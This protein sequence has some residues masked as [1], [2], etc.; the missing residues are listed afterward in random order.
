MERRGHGQSGQIKPGVPWAKRA[1]A[2]AKS[3]PNQRAAGAGAKF[4]E[5]VK[6]LFA[7]GDF[8]PKKGFGAKKGA[9]FLKNRQIN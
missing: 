5:S 2:A 8:L 4:V 7:G 6:A 1:G 3:A 9:N